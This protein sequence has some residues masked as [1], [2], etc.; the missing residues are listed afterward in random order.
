M[1]W[2]AEIIFWT[3]AAVLIYTYAGYPL[4]VFAVSRL[5]PK[6]VRK[7]EI[8]PTVTVLIT[9]YNEE[10]DLR[11]K[12]ENTLQLEYPT[13]KLE[14]LVASDGS[15][16]GTDEIARE[17]GGRGVKLFRQEGRVGKTAT[18]NAA[19]ERAN[20]EIIVF[21]DATTMYEPNVLRAIVPN[22]ADES[23]GCVAGKLIYVD[24]ENSSVGRGAQSYWN[25]ETFLKMAESR[26]CSLIGASGCL[27][28]VRREKYVPMYA[29]ACSDFLIATKIREQNLRTVYEPAAISIEETNNRSDK[30]L[31]MRVRVVAQ[32]FSD[33][34]RHRRMLNPFRTGFYAVQLFSHKVLR[35][36]VPLFLCLIFAA[37]AVLAFYHWI[38]DLTF[39]AQAVFYIVALAATSFEKANE[40]TPRLLVLPQYFVLANIAVVIAFYRFLRGERFAVWQPIRGESQKSQSE[41]TPPE[42]VSI[43]AE[44]PINAPNA[45]KVSVVIPAYNVAEFIGDTLCSVLWQSFRDYEIIVVND[46]SPDTDRLERELKPFTDKIIYLKQPNGGASAARNAGIRAAHGKLIAFL[47]GD[48]I[49]LPEFLVSQVDFL[50]KNRL[51]MVYCN[52]LL[53]GEKINDNQTFMQ[54]ALSR[55]AVTT[56]SLLDFTT[57]V[58]TSGTLVSREKIIAA[59]LFDESPY[60]KRAQDFEMWFRLAKTGAKIAYQR[61]VL[62]KYRVRSGGNLSGDSIAIA[63]RDVHALTGVKNKFVLTARERQ[64]L[65]NRLRIAR[66]VLEVELGKAA[67][68]GSDFVAA[69]K[70]FQHARPHYSAAKTF[71]L[72]VA[73]ALAPQIIQRF[74]LGS[75]NT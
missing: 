57:C 13:E 15:T 71:I 44:P 25:Y 23:V 52:A 35:Y 59:G 31:K 63:E 22:F 67:L 3:S 46:G 26:A 51:D 30:E 61:K 58:I 2:L 72:S 33:L 50:E 34:W 65:E 38:Y 37:N 47:D 9:A 49:W 14:I 39:L 48:D 68:A 21:S 27:Y 6:V 43:V 1:F 29:E 53:F 42:N 55:G 40:K 75:R 73:L 45:P 20:G 74:F 60:W 7:A 5:F 18:Q 28:A 54:N 56:E 69:R 66:A 32:T 70:H 16:D 4:L 12:L 19:V 11:A 24:R 8:E 10:R 64:V 41:N 17:F 62:L 36:S